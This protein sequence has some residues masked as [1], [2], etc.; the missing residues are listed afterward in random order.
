MYLFIVHSLSPYTTLS[1]NLLC[2]TLEY[3]QLPG[4]NRIAVV[5]AIINIL[6]IHIALFFFSF[7]SQ[8]DATRGCQWVEWHEARHGHGTRHGTRHDTRHGT[9][10]H[11]FVQHDT[12]RA[13]FSRARGTTWYACGMG[14]YFFLF[15]R[16]TMQLEVGTALG[17]LQTQHGHSSRHNTRHDTRHGIGTARVHIAWTRF[18]RARGTTR[19]TCGLVWA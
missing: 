13:R 5:A 16:K 14:P 6:N 1:S 4:Q 7:F 10:R 8:N 12:A 17:T 2:E 11:M 3:A 19:H 9:A 18:S 15:S